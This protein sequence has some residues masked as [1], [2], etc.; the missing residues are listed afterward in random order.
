MKAKIFANEHVGGVQPQ[1]AQAQ[2]QSVNG[3]VRDSAPEQQPWEEDIR[4]QVTLE[5]L[6]QLIWELRKEVRELRL[7][8]GSR[9][10]N[11]RR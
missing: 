1:Q 2:A 9:N 4:G 5:T 8:I 11:K 3:L 7:E 10:R 6:Y